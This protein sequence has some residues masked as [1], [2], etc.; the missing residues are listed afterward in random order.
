M[1]ASHPWEVLITVLT[2]SI[3][4]MSMSLYA[5]NSKVCGWNYV[6]HNEEEMKSS[7]MIILSLTR[8]LA[9]MYLY[10]QFRNLRKLGSKYLLGLAG[11]L[12]IFSSFIFSIAIANLLVSDLDGIN[13]A[14]P[15][16]L[17]LVDLSKAGALARIS[18]TAANQ[19]ELQA[20]IGR[21]MAIIGP[22]ITLDALVTTLAI[23][24]GTLSGVKQLETMCCFGCL[25]VIANYL[26]FMTFYPA[27]LSLVLEL[28]KRET[29]YVEVLLAAVD[30][31]V[32]PTTNFPSGK[33]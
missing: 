10:L 23:G 33:Y 12:T 18:L 19:N 14:L 8:C 22:A 6:C 4:L 16:V 31:F 29:G 7:D 28:K 27:A 2:I 5:T 1:C 25:S 21:G 15:F 20:N 32:K 3:S 24:V 17:L 13:Q 11:V 9:V 26:A 30:I